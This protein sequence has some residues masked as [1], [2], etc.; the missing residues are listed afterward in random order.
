MTVKRR[1]ALSNVIMIVVPVVIALCTGLLCLAGIYMTLKYSN[2]F[3][4]DSGSEFYNISQTVLKKVNEIFE[5]GIDIQRKLKSIGSVID[6]S[7]TDL[8]VYENGQLIYSTGNADMVSQNLKLSA[9]SAGNSS[10]VS[11]GKNELYYWSGIS[12]NRT[13]ELYLFSDNSH[14]ENIDVRNAVI[15]SACIL[16]LTVTLSIYFTDRF[17]I[18]FVFEK[19]ETPLDILSDGVKEISNGNLEYRIC[20]EN[21]DEFQP[22]CT[23]FNEMAERLKNSVEE[24]KKNEDSRKEMILDI[25]HDLRS[26][27]TSIQAYVEGILDGIADTPEMRKKYLLTIKRK[28]GDIEKMIAS[29]SAF[30]KLDMNAYAVRETNTRLPEFFK[31]YLR[32]NAEDVPLKVEVTADGVYTCKADTE[33]LERIT[34]NVLNNS[35]KYGN[36][37]NPECRIL[38][39]KEDGYARIE[40]ADNGE[41][42]EEENLEHLFDIFY[43]TD[44]ARSHTGNGSGIGLSFVKKAVELMGGQVKAVNNEQGGLSIVIYLRCIYEKDTDC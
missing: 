18:H 23:S 1:L 31:E 15:I 2:G 27:L 14:Q 40:F 12:E 29:L 16:L 5:D 36:K 6:I 37:D 42:V 11:D 10:F 4:F 41:G 26:P 22:V 35:M 8:Q 44:K 19:I 21:E 17:L 20:Y 9:K 34:F 33:L 3:G 24:I 38:I 13:Y 28:T 30:S 7:S 32:K 25:S 39:H 43:R